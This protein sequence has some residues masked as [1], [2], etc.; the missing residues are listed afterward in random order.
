MSN[1]KKINRAGT[2]GLIF[3]ILVLVGFHE[4]GLLASLLAGSYLGACIVYGE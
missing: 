4:W 2:L 3:S 1:T